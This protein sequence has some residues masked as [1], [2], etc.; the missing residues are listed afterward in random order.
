MSDHEIV[1]TYEGDYVAAEMV[2]HLSTYAACHQ[3]PS[4]DCEQY[5]QQQ[6]ENGWYHNY[7]TED[8]DGNPVTERHEHHSSKDCGIADWLNADS[9]M[10]CAAKGVRFE[11][12][13]TPIEPSWTGDYMEWEP[14]L[15]AWEIELLSAGDPT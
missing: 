5:N 10:E 4:C 15:P 12:A 3:A 9:P 13:R 2:C 7:E 6:D 1:W 14:T 11:I 8:N